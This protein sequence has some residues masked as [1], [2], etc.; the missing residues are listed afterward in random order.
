LGTESRR[1]EDFDSIHRYF[2]CVACD[3][4]WGINPRDLILVFIGGLFTLCE[5][6][7]YFLVL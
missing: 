1:E 7:T 2:Q 5:P 4:G 6:S 3:G